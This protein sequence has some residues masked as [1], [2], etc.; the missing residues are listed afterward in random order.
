MDLR[1]YLKISRLELDP[2]NTKVNENN[3]TES[4]QIEIDQLTS[5]DETSTSS[6]IVE[7][8]RQYILL[9]Y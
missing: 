6:R 8:V 2:D 5:F 3:E 4:S 7:K 1:R 9:L